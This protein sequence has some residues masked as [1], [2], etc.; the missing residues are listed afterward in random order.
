ME[1]ALT[2]EPT[3]S[4]WRQE[5]IDWLLQWGRPDEAHTQALNA[6]YFSPDSQAIR[7]A[8]DRTAEVLARGGKQR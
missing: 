3:Q 5:Y 6:Q 4:A 7:A 8:V 1:A 2:L